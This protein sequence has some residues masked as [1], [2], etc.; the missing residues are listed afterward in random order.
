MAV[1]L[2][3]AA[4]ESAQI[5]PVNA[6]LDAQ[7]PGTLPAAAQRLRDRIWTEVKEA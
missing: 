3:N 6:R 2:P 1:E 7:W 5:S 4:L